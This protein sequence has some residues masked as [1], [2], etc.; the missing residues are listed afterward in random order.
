MKNRWSKQSSGQVKALRF[1]YRFLSSVIQDK[2]VAYALR[3][4]IQVLRPVL[5]Q[6]S[7]SCPTQ[8]S[9][10]VAAGEE[11]L[12]KW[13]KSNDYLLKSNKKIT[14]NNLEEKDNCWK[15]ITKATCI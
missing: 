7:S 8:C 12:S 15:A 9:P 11:F 13:V 10:K 5:E 4:G 2:L 6:E 3:I 14:Q 1:K